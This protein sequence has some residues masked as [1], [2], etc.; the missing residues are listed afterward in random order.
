MRATL[1]QPLRHSF[2]TLA[3]LFFVLSASPLLWR[4]GLGLRGFGLRGL[5]LEKAKKELAPARKFVLSPFVR[6]DTRRGN[7]PKN[8][9]KITLTESE[10]VN[11]FLAIR[12]NNFSREGLRALFD[13]LDQLEDDLG[14]EQ[15][16]DP[17]GIC[18]EWT[19]YDSASEACADFG[20][21]EEDPEKALEWLRDQT[22]VVEAGESVLVLSF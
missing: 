4:G 12:P 7:K 11:R 14:M 20:H 18:C 22:Q 1:F 6:G 5:F 15:E 16:F 8:K 10:F 19:Q 21:T 9:M 2:A 3:S 17:I 13:Y